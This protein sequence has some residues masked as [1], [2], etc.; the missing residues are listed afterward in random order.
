M[1]RIR[2]SLI[3]LIVGL[4]VLLLSGGLLYLKTRMAAEQLRHLA[5]R[6][7]TR[8][9]NL[10]VQIESASPAFLS[11]S[12]ELRGI[13]VSDL[14]GAVLTQADHRIHL[15]LLTIERA[16]VTFR[17]TSLLRGV[18]QVGSLT[19]QGPRLR[20]TDSAASSS[21]LTTL[22][23]TLSE[24]SNTGETQEF[25]V[26]LEQATIAYQR[27]TPPLSVQVDGLT[28]RLDWPSPGQAVVAVATDDMMVRLGVHDLRKIRLQVHARLTRDGVQVEQ[29]SLAKAGSS[30]TVT[31]NIRTGAGRPQPELS[32][33][34]RLSLETLAS[35]LGGAAP[36]NGQL[37]VKGKIV[38][39]ATTQALKASLLLEDGTGRLVGQTDARVQDGLLTVK[40]LS[41]HQG[42]SRLAGDGTINLTTATAD[43]NLDLRGRLE[44]AV[45]WF[46]TDTPV[47][48]PIVGRLRLTGTASS[49]NGAGHIEMH[50]VRIGTEQIDALVARLDLTATV[51]TIPSLTGRYRGIPFKAS[52]AI[53][54]GGGYRFIVLPTRMD[55]ASIRGLADRGAR[56]VLVVSLS[57]AG[58]W[59]EPRVEGELA[60]KD[61]VFHDAKVGNGRIRFTLEE[62]RW[63]WELADS[64]TLRATGVAPLLLAGPLEVDASATNLDLE[65]L[66]QALR[67][68][69]RFPLAVRADGHARLLGTLPE[70]G[71]VAGW[72]DLTNVRGTAGST[73]LRLRQPTRVVLEPEALRIDSLELNGPGLSV[74]V[75]G[76]LEP[77]GRLDLSVSGHA[78]FDII[79]PWVPALRDLQGTP[80]LQLSLA[81]EPGALRVTG[82]AELAHVQVK[83]K[84]IPIWISVETGEVTFNNDRI[85]YIVAA[86][87]LAKGGLKGEGTAQRQGGSWHH[88]LE[89]S[90]DHASLD[91]INDQLLPERHWVSGTLST[92]T[93]LAF[94]TAPNRATIPTLQGQLSM[95]LQDGSLSH[96]PALVRLMGVLGAPA[97][98]YRLPDLTRERMP[99]RRI[100]ADIAVKDGVMQTTNLLL[101]SEV[102]RL[103]AV[104]H[105]TLANQHVDLDLAVRPLQ[106]LEQ[107]IRR[108]PLLGRLLP[109]KQSLAL[110][111]FDM[112]GPW[113]DPT[114]S[115][116]PVKS[117]SQTAR[118]LLLF[119]LRAPWRAIA[120]SR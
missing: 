83:P 45:G 17:L 85:H 50:Q 67:A 89:F 91:L 79:G 74:T 99:Y 55:V 32:I 88:T 72:I 100:S 113:D 57:G 26:V 98:P 106:V 44:D 118:D 65:P 87:A 49:P 13:T 5:E 66:F 93:A 25:P 105:M 37:A 102:M 58:Q 60:L 21:T 95:R 70:L 39:E 84:I 73:P 46:R 77:G 104:G 108:I 34:G 30:L 56:G 71:D 107:G 7:L 22:V 90:V 1:S 42:A 28:G 10:P 48:G 61:L 33:T 82:R 40:H 62:N 2:G 8:E 97:Q 47:S 92:R 112:E 9:L 115:M 12:V 103:T 51:L 76:G 63:R 38:G 116:A 41:L 24:I 114:I 117:L 80:R 68:H 75:T 20:I 36:W 31:G 94:D 109:K 4:V 69:L 23:S 96:Y 43:L 78:P 54:V 81:G 101:D 19:I 119:F 3:L 110:T 6:T 120:P 86:G 27:T 18:L 29:L 15:P 35:R 64:R 14:S 16:L 111:Y 11:G 52:A 59:P 53:E